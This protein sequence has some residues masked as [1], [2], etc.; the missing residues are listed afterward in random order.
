MAFGGHRQKFAINCKILPQSASVWRKSSKRMTE[1]ASI[2][3]PSAKICLNRHP[4]CGNRQTG[5]ENRQRFSGHHPKI[6][7]HRQNFASTGICLAEI[8]K[9]D[10]EIGIHLAGI[11]KNLPQSAS[12]LRKSANRMRE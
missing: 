6:C 5:C 11:G 9:R 2:W 1:S 4:F 3:L 7:H 12:I 8:L 10:D